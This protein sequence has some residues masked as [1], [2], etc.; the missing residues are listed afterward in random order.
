MTSTSRYAGRSTRR[1]KKDRATFRARC[2][3]AAAVC[4]LCEDPR[5]ARIDYTLK[6]PHPESFTVDH[7]I[8]RSKRHDLA[9]D[10]ANYRPSHKVCNERRGADRDPRI[11]IGITSEVW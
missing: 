5:R 3:L 11:P 6:Y 10:P 4:W 1:F 7:F 2:E 8:P 9:E